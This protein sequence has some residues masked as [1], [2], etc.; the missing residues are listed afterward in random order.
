MPGRTKFGNPIYGNCGTYQGFQRHRRYDTLVCKPCND[1]KN[2]WFREW[3]KR[4][5]RT[6]GTWVYV[7]HEVELTADHYSI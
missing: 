5:G 7:P 4:T 2:L 6:A 1:A 3:R